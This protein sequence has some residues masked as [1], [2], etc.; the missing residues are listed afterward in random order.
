MIGPCGLHNNIPQLILKPTR[1]FSSLKTIKVHSQAAL[2]TCLCSSNIRGHPLSSLNSQV[3]S[4]LSYWQLQLTF[5]HL[6]RFVSRSSSP[7]QGV[8]ACAVLWLRW[9]RFWLTS[10]PFLL[11]SSIHSSSESNTSS[12]NPYFCHCCI[13]ILP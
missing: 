7:L 13:F 3:V 8:L 4:S 11:S 1:A 6:S 9:R 5:R 10:F 2:K 12:L